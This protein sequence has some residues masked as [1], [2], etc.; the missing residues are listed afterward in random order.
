MDDSDYVS[1]NVNAERGINYSDYVS[2]NVNVE[3]GIDWE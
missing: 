3:R 1:N 2:N